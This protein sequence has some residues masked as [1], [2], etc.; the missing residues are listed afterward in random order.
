M[1]TYSV[2][3]CVCVCSSDSVGISTRL[4]QNDPEEKSATYSR[5]S[6]MYFLLHLDHIHGLVL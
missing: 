3:D 2:L 5:N 4:F 1:Q 6:V